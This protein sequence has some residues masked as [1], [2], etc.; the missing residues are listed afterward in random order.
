MSK[1]DESARTEPT[2]QRVLVTGAG[3][4]I[5]R[6]LVARLE[7]DPAIERVVAIDLR[8]PAS[9]DAGG[10]EWRQLDVR[11][12][13]LVTLL[14]EGGIESVVH[15]ASIVTP[16]PGMSREEMYSIDVGGT[17]NVVQ[18]CLR[19]RVRRLIVTS[20]GAAYGYHA[21]N[22]AWLEETHPLRGNEEFAYSYHKRL[23]EEYLARQR[24]EQPE[25]IQVVFRLCT[26]LGPTVKNQITALFERPFVLG[27]SGTITP[28]VFVWD[29]DVVEILHRALWRQES[30]VFNVAGDGTV[31]LAEMAATMGK[32]FVRIPRRLLGVALRL[33]R[34]LGLTQ[35]G[36]E[37]VGFLAY[38]PVLSN[39]K[40]KAE[41]GYT[42]RVS[43]REAFERYL[44]ARQPAARSA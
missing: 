20:S 27:V 43:S 32:P 18:A 10:A 13:A 44:A 21:D 25:L 29:E 5:G 36:P 9:A 12:P 15:L 40:L 37:Q 22:P 42:P 34:A 16:P 11:D 8:I 17:E 1:R 14:E 38:R 24:A 28:F 6:R 19:A 7:R 4:F 26:V 35:Y 2:R 30:G 23:I 39:R 31:T 41:F 3:G 33:G